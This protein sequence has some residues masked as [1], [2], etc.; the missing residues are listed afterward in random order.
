MSQYAPC[1]D[2]HLVPDLVEDRKTAWANENSCTVYL[3]IGFFIY[4]YA[5]VETAVS[6][7]LTRATGNQHP[8]HFH[9]L[10]RGMDAK[11]KC[12]RLREALKIS[13]CT[14]GPALTKRF[15]H[16]TSRLSSLRNQ[17]V[18]N[19]PFFHEDTFQLVSVGAPPHVVDRPVKGAPKP[20]MV[21]SLE[22]YERGKWLQA[23]SSDLYAL[24]DDFSDALRRKGT[25][26]RERYWSSLPTGD[27]PS[28]E[29]QARR[30]KV[31]KRVQSPPPK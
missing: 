5:S 4:W 18:H 23:F 10:T 19:Y 29:K 3:H 25:L 24:M 28:P 22:L 2:P 14:I 11:L 7:M 17:L 16:F 27:R 6:I 21:P 8:A 1:Y 13:D 12:E 20:V 15:E 30:A 9:T 31:D 26:E